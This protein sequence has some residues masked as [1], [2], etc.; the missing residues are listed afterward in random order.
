ML[1]AGNGG[2]DDEDGVTAR[3]VRRCGGT[4]NAASR[5]SQRPRAPKPQSFILLGSRPMS[6]ASNVRAE[7]HAA[8]LN[9]T[10]ET[11]P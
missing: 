2:H 9:G 1:R 8:L 4:L 11:E 5:R 3:T 10:P 7:S 6:T